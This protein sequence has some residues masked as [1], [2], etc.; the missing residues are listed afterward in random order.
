MFSF[1][2]R[3]CY[4]QNSTIS[5]GSQISKAQC[6]SCKQFSTNAGFT[7]KNDWSQTIWKRYAKLVNH[8]QL[9]EIYLFNQNIF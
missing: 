5:F 2:P 4:Y 3:Y 9:F 1:I 8:V 7:E 6:Q